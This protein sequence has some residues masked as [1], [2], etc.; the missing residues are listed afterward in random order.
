[1]GK[2]TVKKT[3][4][5][6]KSSA[7]TTSKATKT[8]KTATT[9]ADEK[10]PIV[11]ISGGMLKR[12]FLGAYNLLDKN[13]EYIN[14]MNVFPVPDGD[15]GLNMSLT[16]RSAVAEVENVGSTNIV[17]LTEGIARG[18]FKGARGNSGVITSQIL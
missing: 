7:K 13:K 2:T 12:M 17:E 6:T 18:G 9:V 16:F 5:N 1:M 3:T 4:T 8:T 11:T 14:S 15:T 10:K